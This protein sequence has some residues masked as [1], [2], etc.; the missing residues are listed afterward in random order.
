VKIHVFSEV[1]DK[2]NWCKVLYPAN[3]DEIKE[4]KKSIREY[5]WRIMEEK[6]IARFPRPVYGRIPNFIGA[7]Q[8]AEKV[9]KT[10]VWKKAEVIKANPD[11]PQQPL[12]ARALIEG[13]MLVMASPRLKKG[14]ILLDPRKIPTSRLTYASTIRGAFIYGKIVSLKEIPPVDLVVTGCVAVDLAGNRLGKGGGYAELEYAILRELE[15]INENTPVVTTIHD[16]QIVEKIPR[17]P[18][19]LT[20]DIIATP[21][22]LIHVNPRP[23][24]PT[25][26]I[27]ELLGDKIEL[28]V[29]KELR[30]IKYSK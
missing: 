29:I 23:P 14:F 5:I 11:S 8:A 28:D 21:T 22:K 25:G 1:L 13:K 9:F 10:S 27:W 6:N 26:I 20:V 16:I 30:R 3:K 19:D 18:H 7:E 12:R 17:E 2:I 4:V 15:L 24:K